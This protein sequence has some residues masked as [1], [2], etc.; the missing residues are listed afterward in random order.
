MSR[1]DSW[2]HC[3]YKESIFATL[4]MTYVPPF[5]TRNGVK[6]SNSLMQFS[7]SIQMSFIEKKWGTAI[8]IRVLPFKCYI[9]DAF[10]N[11]ICH[12]SQVEMTVNDNNREGKKIRGFY[13]AQR[14]RDPNQLSHKSIKWFNTVYPSVGYIYITQEKIAH[15]PKTRK[16][17]KQTSHW[18][19]W[20]LIAL[21]SIAFER[22]W[23]RMK[24]LAVIFGEKKPT[25][26]QLF[27]NGFEIWGL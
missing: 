5:A 7:K 19:D 6:F 20:Q 24:V 11:L 16:R 22:M 25:H 8:G 17:Y 18:S 21:T 15:S 9:L 1:T 4:L 2:D 10:G 12:G 3:T 27:S 23:T 26:I 14:P 13:R